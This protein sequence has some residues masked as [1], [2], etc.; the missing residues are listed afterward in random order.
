MNDAGGFY[1]LSSAPGS[2]FEGNYIRM[3]EPST[4]LRG[5]LYFDEGSRY[6]TVRDNVLDVERAQLF[7]QRPNNHTGDNTYVDNWV[8]G[9]S[10]DFAGRG[11]VVSGSVQLGRG[12]TVPP[13]AARIIYNSGVSPRLRD[14]PDPTRPELAVEM[15]AESDAVEPGSNVTATAKLTNLSEDLVLSGLRLTATVPEGWR[16]SPAGNTPASLKPGRTSSVEL[17]VTAPATA[18][19][20]I[21][22]GTVRV[23]VDY[24]V[25]GTRNSGSG[26]VTAL[27]V[28]PLTSLSSFGSVPSTFGE[29]AG[30][31]AIHNA[32]A[33]IWGGGGQND[34]EYGTVYSPDAAH[35][36]SVVTVRVDAVEEINPWTKAGLVLRN[37]VTAAR[38]G[39]G[40]VVMV[41][42]PGNGVSL[43]W[44]SNADGL[45]DQWRQTG[46]VTAP[47]WLRL[48]RSGDRVTGSYS[49]DGTTWTQLGAPVTLTGAAADQDAGMIYTS[50]STQA[51]QATFSE[52]SID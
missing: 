14:A 52:F 38:Q 46:G 41:A 1:N 21:D 25:Y 20:P 51:G 29:L 44:D 16:V 12:E 39:Q 11:N 13:K 22:A 2:V 37:D 8:V 49:N 34:D 3:P 18:S 36:G 28:S 45:L 17:V 23:T 6:W 32:G 50:H 10:A 48:A 40:Y 9:A 19:V 4:A 47:V 33:D 35:D 5:G 30:V 27:V 24:S 31:Y 26:R 42:T 43:Q 15:S 7:N